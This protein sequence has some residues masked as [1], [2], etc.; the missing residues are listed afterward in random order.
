MIFHLEPCEESGVVGSVQVRP[1]YNMKNAGIGSHLS[2][3][4]CFSHLW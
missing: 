1:A 2:D 4:F 3:F